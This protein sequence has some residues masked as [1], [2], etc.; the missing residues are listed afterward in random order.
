MRYVADGLAITEACGILASNKVG[1]KKLRLARQGVDAGQA[2]RITE[3]G[4]RPELFAAAKVERVASAK[5][6][7]ILRDAV[8]LF[9]VQV[10]L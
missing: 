1:P 10:F 2:V 8:H 7:C 3:K 4:S 9:I 6:D 5:G